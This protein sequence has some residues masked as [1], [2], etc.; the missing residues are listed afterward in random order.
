VDGSSWSFQDHQRSLILSILLFTP[1]VKSTSTLFL[2]HFIAFSSL[3]RVLVYTGC[4]G[5]PNY[6]AQYSQL[7]YDC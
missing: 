6:G 1:A 2:V 4:L 3:F 7:G 5:I